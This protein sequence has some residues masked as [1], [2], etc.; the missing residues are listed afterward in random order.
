MPERR[1]RRGSATARRALVAVALLAVTAPTVAAVAEEDG[2][3][4]VAAFSA[5]V[6]TALASET[7]TPED[8]A[9]DADRKPVETL[10][11]FGIE[12]GMDVLELV[13]GGGWYTEILAP[14]LAGTG[15][16]SVWIGIGRFADRFAALGLESVQV[17]APGTELV[18]TERR[19]IFELPT[20][21]F[22]SDA[23][24]A[25]LTFRNLHN[26][27][28][29]A[30]AVTNRA[31]F[32][33]LRSGGVYGVVDHTRRHMQPDDPENRRRLDP[34]RVI[35]EVEAAGFV[36]EGW[37]DL[38]YH[39]DDELRYEVGRRS[40]SGNTDRFTLRFRKL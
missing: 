7:R 22:G 2:V 26:L 34:V 29:A 14:S 13:P 20:V 32:T 23:F 24:D 40:V 17:V 19:G 38:H 36:F 21:D 25:V 33:A 35:H 18:A 30:R 39:L 12:P 11:F 31:V 28:P 15:S 16:L 10:A 4:A 5:R 6:G 37:S 27:T 8:R 1:K 9:R 3:A